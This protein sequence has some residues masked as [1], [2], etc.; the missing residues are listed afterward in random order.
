MSLLTRHTGAGWSSRRRASRLDGAYARTHP[1]ICAGP[2]R[3]ARRQATPG[4]AWTATDAGPRLRA[5]LHDRRGPGREPASA[6]PSCFGI[7]E[8]ERGG[9]APV[10][11]RA[12]PR[13]ETFKSLPPTGSRDRTCRRYRPQRRQERAAW[14]G[15]SAVLVVEDEG[16]ACEAHRR[17]DAPRRRVT[18]S[19]RRARHRARPRPLAASSPRGD[20]TSCI[21]DVVLPRPE[22]T[23]DG[24]QLR[25][26]PAPAC[27][28][29]LMSG[30]LD[31]LLSGQRAA[32][33]TTPFLGKPLR[34][35]A[36]CGRCAGV[37][38]GRCL[39]CL[40]C[41]ARILVVDDSRPRACDARAEPHRA[42]FFTSD[43]RRGAARWPWERR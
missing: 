22:R 32:E 24:R 43:Q 16:C 2:L 4:G 19:S 15:R 38:S 31:R 41:A 30:Y 17:G 27:A 7:R 29:L 11:Q 1:E 6:S 10:S 39:R 40:E 14:E 12:G 23:R 28:A 33:V 35:T 26:S 18:P 25:T 42:G 9:T 8:A 21:T 34:S 5:L 20:P 13:V 37:G 3:R 36:C